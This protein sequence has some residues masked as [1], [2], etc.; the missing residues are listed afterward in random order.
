MSVTQEVSK[1]DKSRQ[2]KDEQP[3]N[4]SL[5]SVTQEVSKWDKSIEVR[6]EQY[7]NI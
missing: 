4:M 1:W 7:R 2:V 3:E 6:A 5:M